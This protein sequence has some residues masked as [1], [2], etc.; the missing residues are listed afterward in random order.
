MSQ[1]KVFHVG[2][3]IQLT[4]TRYDDGSLFLS[5]LGLGNGFHTSRHVSLNDVSHLS[6]LDKLKF[7]CDEIEHIRVILADCN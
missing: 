2:D 1:E 4:I 7:I 6:D 5:S 3:A